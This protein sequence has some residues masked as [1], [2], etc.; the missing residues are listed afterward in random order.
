M[1]VDKSLILFWN[2]LMSHFIYE[3]T[4]TIYEFII[5]LYL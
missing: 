5:K 3:K 2:V 1:S 4:K